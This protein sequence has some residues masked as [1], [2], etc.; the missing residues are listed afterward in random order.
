M[1]QAFVAA[2]LGHASLGRE[3]AV[4]NHQAAGFLQR[5]VQRR[6]HFLVRRFDGASCFS[7]QRL[8][9]H[10]HRVLVKMFALQQTVRQ[11]A[12]SS[13]AVHIGSDKTPRRLQVGQQRR[14]FADFLE[15]VDVQGDAGLARDGEQVQDGVGRASGGGDSR[16]RVLECG[17]REDVSGS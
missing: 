13:G 2:D 11:Q 4:Q 17:A 9:A 16:D 5:L 12:N 10:R 15:I 6:N 7:A 1:A 3:V 8:A 14:A